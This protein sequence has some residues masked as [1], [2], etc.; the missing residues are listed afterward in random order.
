MNNNNFQLEIDPS[1]II[2]LGEDMISRGSEYNKEIESIYSTVN[3]LAKSW[4]GSSST[5]FVKKL[6]DVQEKYEDFG[7]LINEFGAFIQ[8]IGIAYDKAEKDL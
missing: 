5:Q 7:K 8:E 6:T 4:K 1:K 2:K 3:T